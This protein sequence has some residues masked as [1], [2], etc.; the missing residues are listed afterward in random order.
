MKKVIF[1]VVFFYVKFTFSQVGNVLVVPFGD[2]MFYNEATV[3]MLNVSKVS[4]AEMIRLFENGLV[5]AIQQEGGRRYITTNIMSTTTNKDIKWQI[6][7][8]LDFSS[9]EVN[10]EQQNEKMRVFSKSSTKIKRKKNI[11]NNEGEVISIIGSNGN[12]FITSKVNSKKEFARICKDLNVSN[13]L[14][15]NEMDIK[16]DYSTPYNNGKEY[17]RQIQVHFSFFDNKGKKLASGIA[18]KNFPSSV[19]KI[20]DIINLYFKDLAKQ[21]L[22]IISQ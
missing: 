3:K 1:L 2:R 15:I 4:Y 7:A 20:N 10:L 8:L 13:V 12:Q 11:A 21:I 9:E 17:L 16:E 22:K 18:L 19:N 14:V 6:R 5:T